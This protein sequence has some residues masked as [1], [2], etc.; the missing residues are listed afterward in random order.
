M[1]V[2]TASLQ[3]TNQN[4]IEPFEKLGRLTADLASIET[5]NMQPSSELSDQI[6]N[7]LLKCIAVRQAMFNAQIKT[8]SSLKERCD[9]LPHV[10]PALKTMNDSNLETNQKRLASINKLEDIVLTGTHL[11]SQQ[12]RSICCK[13][14]CPERY[15]SWL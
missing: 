9:Q 15:N 5:K 7:T 11:T 8:S 13:M 3:S 14:A 6:R 1:A 12:L 2:N 4:E 10:I